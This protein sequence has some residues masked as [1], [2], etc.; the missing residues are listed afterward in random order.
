MKP[1]HIYT[2]FSGELEYQS[3]QREKK[4]I[5]YHERQVKISKEVGDRAGEGK[6]YSS[7]G[8]AY[9]TTRD[10]KNA[11]EYHERHLKITKEV[12]DRAGEARA[13]RNLGYAY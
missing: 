1:Q 3:Q 12:G 11:I 4:A 13:H 10:F 7:L 2:F 5:E 9:Y 8:Y 6:A